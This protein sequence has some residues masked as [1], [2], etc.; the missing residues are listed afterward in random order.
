MYKTLNRV[1]KI[2]PFT[3][4]S[5]SKI[6]G[7]NLMKE[8]KDL[9]NKTINHS[10]MKLKKTLEDGI[11]MKADWQNQHCKN[12][13]IPESIHVITVVPI[14]IPVSSSRRKIQIEAEKTLKSE[15]K[16]QH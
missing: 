6:P 12:G 8:V 1:R 16:K 4:V 13:Y 14:K 3:I 15:H 5:I 2:I 9:Y 10:K 7:I 11:G